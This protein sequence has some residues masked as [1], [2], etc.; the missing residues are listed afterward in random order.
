LPDLH[1]HSVQRPSPV[2]KFDLELALHERDGAIVGTLGYATALFERSTVQRLLAS[3]VHLLRAMPSHD[4]VPVARLPLLDA[5]Q[6]QQLLTVF[7]TGA[8]VAIPAQPVH[9]LFEAQAQ[10]TPDAI[11]VVADQQCVRYAA[12]DARANRLAQRLLALGL[13]TGAQVAIALPRSIELIVAQLAVLKCAAAYV[14]LDSAHPRERLLALIADAQAQV[15][16]QEPDGTLAPAGVACLSLADFDEANTATPP[17]ITVP[18]TATAYVIYTSGSTGMPKG[19]AVSHGAILNLVLQDGPARLHSQDRVAFASNPA[20]DSATLEVW[21]SL[22]NGAT[23][24]VVPAA[25]MRDPVAL[26]ALLEQQRLSVL[27]LV[28][29]VL[30]AY[31]PSMASPLS[32]LRLLLTG[33]DVADPHALAQVLDAG[34]P[35]RVLQ[36]YGPT[37]STQFVTALTV[38]SAP[39]PRQRVPIG[40][41][42]ANTRLYVLDRQG[43]PVP[44]GVAG[45]LHIAGA[46]LAQGYLQRPDL[47]AERFVPDPFAEQPGQRMYRSGDLAC[48]RADGTLDFLGRNDDQVKLRGFRIEPGEI[49]AA[50][51]AC[52]VRETVV[53]ADGAEDK[54]LIAYLVCDS[55]AA[56]PTALRA[57]LATRLPEHMIPAAFVQLDMLPLTPNGKLDRAALPAP[58]T[59]ALVATAYAAPE[60]EL[61]M[62]LAG[63]WRELLDVAQVGRHDDFFALGGHSLLAV[64]LVSR[65]R[66]RLGVELAL[67][68]VFAH[69]QMAQ[70]ARMLANAAPQ[71]LPPIVPVPRD[72]PLPLSF[73]QQRLWFVAQFDPQVHLAY[74]MMLRMRIRGRLHAQ[75]LRDALNQLVARHEPLRT[76]IG[77]VDGGAVQEIA[78]ATIG[79]ALAEIDLHGHS[80]QETEIQRHAEQE[81]NT[82]FDANDASLVRGRLLRLAD[83]EHVLLLTVHHLVSD[84]WSM[85]LLT[86]ELAALYAAFVQQRPNPLQALPI[87]YADVAVWQRRWLG[88]ESLQRQRAFWLEHL[89]NAPALLELPTDRPRPALQDY[90]GDAVALA[91]PAEL[92]AAL[93]ALSQRHGT[94]LFMTV[95]AAWSALLSRLSGQQQVVIG[96]PI[97]N[98]TRSELEPLIGLFVNTQALHIDLR[99][100]PSVAELLAQVRRT[101]LA[102]H[103]HQDLPFEQLIEAL[104]PERNLAHHPVCQ[105]T[106]AWQNTPTATIAL[107]GLELQAIQAA[108]GTIK[109][110]L[111]LSLRETEDRIVG[112]LY[113]ATALFDRSSIERQLAQFVQM[114]AGM[115]IGEQARVA[116][117]PLLPADERAQLQRFTATE[118]AP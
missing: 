23:V 78:A 111:E 2:S 19:V 31:A 39:D 74:L 118:T 103:E 12:L 95:L 81:A 65:L 112:C 55:A 8:S 46:Q 15:L 45:A 108:P 40:R 102:A 76:R 49:E 43:V 114:L 73:A 85:D 75:A 91:V 110:D 34:G 69:P 60:G 92:T 71:I 50:L 7:G 28:A 87:Q 42:L 13:R 117:L 47:T 115:V 38:D 63:L 10:R 80:A 33:G 64:R 35:V 16:I 98:R 72:R 88:G 101:A 21:G 5:P 24:V 83:D 3:F 84:G 29:G 96:T 61:E 14:P 26:G 44:I 9:R 62:L 18:A 99:A 100:N 68:D 52:G 86:Q 58:N 89:R 82:A 97:A 30:R 51:R 41:P 90:R 57:Q 37:E 94:T 66:E 67:A 70:L 79:F 113:Y 104:N 77:I 32:A 22:L 93:N 17:A 1:L 20:F 109:I 59:D 6:C 107:S 105:V 54:R 4:H 53:V 116:Q 36:T 25:V 106:L 11:A 56:D 27:I 48:W